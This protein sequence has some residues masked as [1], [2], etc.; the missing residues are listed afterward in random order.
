MSN[1]IR[2]KRRASGSAG[3]PSTLK[4]GELAFNEVDSILYY[5]KGTSGGGDTAANVIPIATAGTASS[6]SPTFDEL[7][8]DIAD[9]SGTA[10][11][12]NQVIVST[13]AGAFALESGTTLRTSLGLGTG[14][15]PTFTGL[16]TTSNASVGGT[17]GVTGVTTLTGALNA[18]GGITTTS[19]NLALNSASG[20]VDID[21]AVDI[22]GQVD[23][24][25]ALAGGSTLAISG[26]TTLTGALN[27]N[28]GIAV[29]TNKFTVADTSGNVATA[30][31][32][33]VTGITTLSAL[34]NADGGIAVDTNK[35]TV[36]AT[37]NTSIGGTLAV[38]GVTTLDGLINADGG[39]A[40]GTNKFTVAASDGDTLIA[41]T[42]GVTGA[43]TLASVSAGAL[44]L[45]TD[46]AIADGG[47]GASTASAAASNLGLGTEDSP[48]FTQVTV[49][50]SGGFVGSGAGLTSIPAG[51]LTG[52]INKDRLP[53]ATSTNRGAIELFSNTTQTVA[54]N[55][56]SDTASR[57]YGI[58]LNS[59]GQAV[60]NV[61]WTDAATSTRDSLGIDT[62]D[63]VTFKNLTLGGASGAATI[64][65]PAEITI[66]PSTAGTGG[67]VVI[68]GDLQVTGTTTTIN[69]TTV[70]IDDLVIE[71]ANNATDAAAIDGAGIRI[72]DGGSSVELGLVEF[73][74]NNGQ[75]RMELSS[76]MK[77][78]GGLEA[79]VI[80]GG[81]F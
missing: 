71:L 7:L 61:P 33:G 10:T 53:V 39:I 2:I 31:T 49:S 26:V 20:L 52:N 56:V 43:T 9:I 29:D 17:L 8:Q 54:A 62:D 18:N 47:T 40:V 1:S 80:D 34:L 65:G 78:T 28:G 32:L 72:G 76:A 75:T 58:Q 19:G 70:Q 81:T 50:G 79:T 16:N 21:D 73:L 30:G 46:L 51:E 57:T 12:A 48:T 63:D 11:A 55:T 64:S 69:S 35:F 36:A 74:W 3:A 4:N 5:G 24:S 41:G 37:G 38:D 60:V 13:G 77:I 22:S 44:I 66:D 45:T 27:A 15:S 6:S 23:I 14:N 67:K 59:A 68:A 25:G 42:L